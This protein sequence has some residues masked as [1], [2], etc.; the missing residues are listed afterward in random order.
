[1]VMRTFWHAGTACVFGLCTLQIVHGVGIHVAYHA[2]HVACHA[3]AVW[4][5]CTADK[6]SAVPMT[7]QESK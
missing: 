6:A 3:C 2:A 7:L 4:Y 1:M 5:T